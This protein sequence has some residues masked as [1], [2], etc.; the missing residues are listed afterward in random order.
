MLVVHVT[1]MAKPECRQQLI[2]VLATDG[3]SARA[4]PGCH[5]FELLGDLSEPQRLVL[6]EEW[7]T[8]TSFAAYK[9]S[10][11]FGKVMKQVPPL[12]AVPPKSLYVDGN[13][14]C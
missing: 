3:E 11:V 5:R 1:L 7:E 13:I 10:A 6:I 9:S 8:A 2:D 4:I 14:V 12:L